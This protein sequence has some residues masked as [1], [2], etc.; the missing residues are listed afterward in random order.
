MV[1]H[2]LILVSEKRWSKLISETSYI[3]EFWVWLRD[4]VLVNKVEE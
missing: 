1:A 2:F 4:L 3:C